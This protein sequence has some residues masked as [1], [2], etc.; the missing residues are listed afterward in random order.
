MVLSRSS[1]PISKALL[2]SLLT[3][4]LILGAVA[5]AGA[6]SNGSSVRPASKNGMVKNYKHKF[7]HSTKGWSGPGTITRVQSGTSTNAYAPG[8]AAESSPWYA[9]VD[10]Q[11]DGS[12]IC[13]TPTQDQS[14]PS[15]FL[16]WGNPEGNYYTF[17]TNGFTTSLDIYLDTAWGS[18]N[19]GVEFEWDTSLNQSN[20]QFGQDFIFTAQTG[21]DGFTIG[22]GNNTRQSV[23][24]PSVTIDT[25]GWYRFEYQFSVDPNSGD[26]EAT[27]SVIDDAYDTEVPGASWILPVMFSG[28]PEPPANVGGPLYGWF[29]NENIPFLPVD[30][31]TVHV[32]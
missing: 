21:V 10:G 31:P 13:P 2:A 25:S 20:G 18:A 6:A 7:N 5:T 8:I 4:G 12:S 24:T 11:N 22:T 17:P 29:P 27:L 30:N 16:D 19:P 3:G 9:T 15:P 32:G 28:D 1:I 23:P 26:V 14:C